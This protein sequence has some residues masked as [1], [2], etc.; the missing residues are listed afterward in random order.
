[1]KWV[2]T[3]FEQETIHI[4]EF[5]TKEEAQAALE[6]T[7]YPAVITFTNLYLVA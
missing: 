7:N 2:L 6:I 1:M 3:V 4:Y 5:D